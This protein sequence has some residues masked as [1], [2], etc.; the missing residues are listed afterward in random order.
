MD[1]T[2]IIDNKDL[3]ISIKNPNDYDYTLDIISEFDDGK[4]HSYI[5]ETIYTGRNKY[6]IVLYRLPI[7][8]NNIISI[9]I[10]NNN[11]GDIMYESPVLSVES[12]K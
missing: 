11:T 3:K 4:K 9:Q 8:Q 2:T 10:K 12:H 7:I 1:V 5:T 6:N